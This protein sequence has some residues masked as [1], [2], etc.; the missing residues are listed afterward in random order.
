MIHNSCFGVKK[1]QNNISLGM[2]KITENALKTVV[3]LKNGHIIFF[4]LVENQLFGN[5]AVDLMKI[6]YFPQKE[7]N[8]PIFFSLMKTYQI[9]CQNDKQFGEERGR[10]EGCSPYVAPKTTRPQTILIT[11]ELSLSMF[12]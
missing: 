7:N 5:S 1:L 11:I 8:P 12:S 6:Q 2:L 4:S 10:I 3:F 9:Y